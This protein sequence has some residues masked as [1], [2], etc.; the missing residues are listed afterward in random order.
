M[1]RANERLN[2]IVKILNKQGRVHTK[3]L[4][5]MFDVTEDL[6]RKDLKNVKPRNLMFRM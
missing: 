2:E 4:S 6:I 3:D 1:M 5:L